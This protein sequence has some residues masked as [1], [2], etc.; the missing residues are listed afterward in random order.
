MHPEIIRDAAD[1]CPQCGMAL[2]PNVPEDAPSA[3]LIDFICRM[4]ISTAASV[5]LIVLTKGELIG[6]PVRDWLGHEAA[7]CIEF[8]L[9]T[10][11]VLWAALRLFQ[12]GWTSVVTRTPNIWT[13]IS[14]GVAVA[15]L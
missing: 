2:K 3:G 15:Y 4:W 10:P 5:P 7:S 12:R 13:L 1:S 6:L 11:I 14:L 9:A 8:A